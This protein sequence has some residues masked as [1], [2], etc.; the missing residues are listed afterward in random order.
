MLDWLVLCCPGRLGVPEA[1]SGVKVR[2]GGWPALSCSRLPSTWVGE[3]SGLSVWLL[4]CQRSSRGLSDVWG[5]VKA[6]AHVLLL[7]VIVKSREAAAPVAGYLLT[8]PSSW[9]R[10]PGRD[11]ESQ[12]KAGGDWHEKGWGRHQPSNAHKGSQV[13]EGKVKQ[14]GGHGIVRARIPAELTA[15]SASATRSYTQ[16]DDLMLSDHLICWCL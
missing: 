16:H 10:G 2:R 11:W 5:E 4:P 12:G 13:V 8:S 9:E 3:S 15:A 7:V 6:S 1:D 14:E